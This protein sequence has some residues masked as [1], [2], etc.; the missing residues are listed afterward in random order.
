MNN[1]LQNWAEGMDRLTMHLVNIKRYFTAFNK[2]E[3]HVKVFPV[4]GGILKED[5]FKAWIDPL[6]ENHRLTPTAFHNFPMSVR[7]EISPVNTAFMVITFTADVTD[8][9]ITVHIVRPL[10]SNEGSNMNNLRQSYSRRYRLE[11]EFDSKGNDGTFGMM[12]RLLKQCGV[13]DD[14]DQQLCNTISLLSQK[15]QRATLS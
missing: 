3:D 6:V 14:F 8:P 4:K 12:H 7:D 1:T 11:S 5:D 13:E 2:I 10:F 15:K 9:Y